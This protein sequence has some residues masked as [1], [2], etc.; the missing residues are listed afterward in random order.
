M[1]L[2]GHLQG[3]PPA[4]R[5]VGARR[6][7]LARARRGMSGRYAGKTALVTGAQGFIGSW[8]AEGLLDEGA[9]GG[10]LGRAAPALSRFKL[11]G[12]DERCD[13][14]QGDQG[15]YEA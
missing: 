1:G 7:S 5:A 2:H 13:I 15:E 10:G 14:A 11:E 4:E 6:G 9:Q 3:H 8:L 12:I